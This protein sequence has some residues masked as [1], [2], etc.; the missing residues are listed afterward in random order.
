MSF[1]AYREPATEP[2]LPTLLVLHGTGGDE[3]SLVPIA[4]SVAPGAAILSLRGRID[5]RGMP[6]FFRRFAEG[7]FDY[8]NIRD[9]AD[10]LAEFLSGEPGEKV[11]FGYSNGANMAW[12]LVL[13]HPETLAGGILL[14]P[15]RTL[16]NEADLTGKKFFVSSGRFD[17]I[18]PVEN[19]EA[20][21]NQ[22]KERG[23]EVR[24]DLLPVGHELNRA[25]LETAREWFDAFRR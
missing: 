12:S 10:A 2:G 11:A 5:E 18:V 16:E 24:F 19:V 20:L 14:R 7:V 22:M 21:V 8:D 17:P 6:R 13:R 9:E 25:E 15:M 3:T 4:K 23:A 1:V